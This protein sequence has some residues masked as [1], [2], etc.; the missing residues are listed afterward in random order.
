M[1]LLEFNYNQTRD[2]IMEVR[3]NKWQIAETETNAVKRN[4]Y[5]FHN[6]QVQTTTITL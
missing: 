2:I 5:E 3:V 6:K 1:P 4:Q